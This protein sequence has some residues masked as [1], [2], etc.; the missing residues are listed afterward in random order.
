MAE[1]WEE[2]DYRFSQEASER[3][4]MIIWECDRCHTTREDYPGVNEGGQCY[5]GG[6]YQN[7]GESYLG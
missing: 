4:L 7:V 3:N 1:Y 2:E 6:W 5:C